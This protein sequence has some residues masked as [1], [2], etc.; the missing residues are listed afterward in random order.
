MKAISFLIIVHNPK[1][2]I[3][4]IHWGEFNFFKSDDVPD[5]LFFIYLTSNSER[6]LLLHERIALILHGC[7]WWRQRVL[8][9]RLAISNALRALCIIISWSRVNLD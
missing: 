3:F 9:D 2:Y 5:S 7:R 4:N 6:K 8:F 1:Y